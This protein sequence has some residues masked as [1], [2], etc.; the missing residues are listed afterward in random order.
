M[1]ELPL[2]HPCPSLLPAKCLRYEGCNRTPTCYWLVQLNSQ[3]VHWI[4]FNAWH[5]GQ[6]FWQIAC[7]IGVAGIH[8]VKRRLT[9]YCLHQKQL[10]KH[11]QA[12]GMRCFDQHAFKVLS[13]IILFARRWQWRSS[14][15]IKSLPGISALTDC[16]LCLIS[17]LGM[18]R[19][20]GQMRNSCI[21]TRQLLFSVK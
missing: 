17:I 8:C 19:K 4:L 16:P 5:K 10:A 15:K 3:S 21:S 12:A 6:T 2:S 14:I 9:V 18:S 7:H 13:K 11:F 1:V 20:Q